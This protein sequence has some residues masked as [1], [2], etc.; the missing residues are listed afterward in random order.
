M[1]LVRRQVPTLAREPRRAG[2]FDLS[3]RN[4]IAPGRGQATT[5]GNSVHQH[6]TSA[7]AAHYF[8][9]PNAVAVD[10]VGD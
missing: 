4:R 10:G 3:L 9:A 7:L 1:W 8:Q 5:E 2:C 6:M